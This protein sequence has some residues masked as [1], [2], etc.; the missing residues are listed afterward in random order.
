MDDDLNTPA[1]LLALEALAEDTADAAAARRDV[2]KA[3]DALRA[4]ATVLGLRL[5][6]ATPEARVSDGWDHHLQRF[7]PLGAP[8]TESE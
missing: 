8:A 6:S 2:G 1:A 7:L 5:N 4:F 3:Q